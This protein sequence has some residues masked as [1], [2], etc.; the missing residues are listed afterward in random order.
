MDIGEIAPDFVLPLQTGELIRL[1]DVWGE[2]NVVLYFYPRDFTWGCTREG[3][4]FSAN[5]EEIKRLNATIVGISADS[6]ESHKRF[7]DTYHF[8]FALASDERMEVCRLYQAVWMRG[9]AVRRITY[10]IDQRGVIRGKAHH[11]I[12]IERHWK[13]VRRI[14]R[15]LNGEEAPGRHL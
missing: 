8:P 12:L 1:S 14:L 7:S 13:Y 9:M 3:C 11:E 10:I 2:K 4:V 15:E 6:V 5:V